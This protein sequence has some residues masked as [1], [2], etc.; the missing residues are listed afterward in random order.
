VLEKAHCKDTGQRNGMSY[1]Q[2]DKTCISYP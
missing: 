2:I 1:T